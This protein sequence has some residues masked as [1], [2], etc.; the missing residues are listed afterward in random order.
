M[1][2]IGYSEGDIF[3]SQKVN[4]QNYRVIVE[5]S[6]GDY[7]TSETGG[8]HDYKLLPSVGFAQGETKFLANND[9]TQ[10]NFVRVL[11]DGN[12]RPGILNEQLL[13]VLIDRLTKLNDKYPDKNSE[14]AIEYLKSA[15][16]FLEQR[17]I[18][19]TER[20]VMGKL[21]K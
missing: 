16:G 6:D 4:G 7:G 11:P 14:Q 18:E 17:I 8:A 1:T 13:L 20:G 21:E 12:I 3:L 15:L 9:I 2:Y 19:R 5:S 10:L